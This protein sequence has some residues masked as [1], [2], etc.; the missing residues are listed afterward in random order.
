MRTSAFRGTFQPNARPYLQIASDVFVS[1]Q[2]ETSVISCGECRREVNFNN[3]ITQISTEASVDSPPGSASFTLSIPENDVNDF[4]VDDQLTIIPMM[5]VEIFAKGYFTVG[6]I[7]QYYKIFWGMVSTVTKSWSNG[8]TTIQVSCKDILR[9]WELTNV[10]LN[11][12]YLTSFGS[13]TNNFTMFGNQFASMNPYTVIVQLAKEA[14]GDFS[15]TQGSFTSFTPDSGAESQVIGAYA[16]DIMAYW[17][18][19]FANIWNSLV[20]YGSSGRSYTFSGE[21]GT[22][23]GSQI[24]KTIIEQEETINKMEGDAAG[25]STATS[26]SAFKVH[27]GQLAAFKTELARAADIDFFQT[28]SESKLSVALTARDQAGYEFYCDTTGDIVFKPP[29]YN[30]NV[31]PNKPVS[32][33]QDF[34]IIDDS[35]TDSEAEVYTHITSSGNAFSGGSVDLGLNDDIT[36]PR[37][38]VFD[39]HLLRR[40]GWRR[41]DYQCEWASN[42]RQLFFHLIDHL[43]RVNSKR[44]NGSVTIPMRSELRMGFP[45]WIPKH[46]SFFYINGITHNHS[47]GGQSTSSLTLSAKRSK[48]IAPSNIGK[49]EKVSSPVQTTSKTDPGTG[50]KKQVSG[51]AK[52]PAEQKQQQKPQTTY[53]ITFPQNP[54][55][56]SGI[57]QGAEQGQPQI[58]RDPS[59]GKL[60]GFPNVCMVFQKPFDG[61]ILAKINLDTPGSKKATVE[62]NAAKKQQGSVK[63]AAPKQNQGNNYENVIKSVMKATSGQQ[64]AELIKRL[65]AHRYET[66]MTNAGAYD[67]AYDVGNNFKE[68]TM[69]PVGLVTWGDGSTDPSARAFGSGAE[70]EAEKKKARELEKSQIDGQKIIKNAAFQKYLSAIGTYSAALKNFN[71]AAKKSLGGKKLEA[72]QALPPEVQALKDLS[73]KAKAAEAEANNTYKAEEKRLDELITGSQTKFKTASKLNMMVRPVS[74]EFGFELIG[75]YRYGRGAFIDRGKIQ[76]ADPNNGTIANKLNIQFAATG[77]L[78][79][80]GPNT[81][82]GGPASM[83][84]SQAFEDMRPEDYTTGA[85]FDHGVSG[86]GE[87]QNIST[88][89]QNTYDAAIMASK[90]RTGTIVFADADATRRGVTL[91]ELKPTTTTGLSPGFEKCGCQLGKTDWLSVLPKT[92]LDQILR[93]FSSANNPRIA[94]LSNESGTGNFVSSVST[95]VT[96]VR[97]PSP[98]LVPPTAETQRQLTDAEIDLAIKNKFK[99]TDFQSSA[100]SDPFGFSKKSSVTASDNSPQEI[101][102]RGGEFAPNRIPINTG[103]FFDVLST[104][105][106]ERFTTDYVSNTIREREDV[107]LNFGSVGDDSNGLEQSNYLENPDAALFDRAASGDPAALAALQKDANFNFGRTS[108]AAEDFNQTAEENIDRARS[109]IVNLP[110]QVAFAAENGINVSVTTDSQKGQQIEEARRALEKAEFDLRK[111]EDFLRAN[112]GSTFAQNEVNRCKN[113]YTLASITYSNLTGSSPQSSTPAAAA[114]V[115]GATTAVLD[116]MAKAA[117]NPKD[118]SIQ[119][120][121]EKAKVELSSAQ[122]DLKASKNGKVNVSPVPQNTVPVRPPTQGGILNPSKFGP[123][124]GSFRIGDPFP[125]IPS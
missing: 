78:L 58:I 19:K 8:V 11:P 52:K 94:D 4:Y 5:E 28:D 14:M 25:A 40:Y 24:T 33:I 106:I 67:Y 26:D 75:H 81:D 51:K 74:D 60:L 49:I 80:D 9:W 15:L 45:V 101:D 107:G 79:T 21:G 47:V 55:D 34:E 96:P 64:Q 35:I 43:D 71:D 68:I 73:D 109:A 115:E 54:G 99:D 59:T 61:D 44:Q 92:A 42:P 2:G 120:A 32:W 86:K 23:S 88:T 18:L 104:Y 93:P 38:G 62:K 98:S 22:V 48:F 125:K 97:S 116:L 69:V 46:D 6:G 65:R 37:T 13:S 53:K 36:T 87:V 66:G 70:F 83:S 12:A 82:T 124:F 56:T 90:K 41:L 84:F 118:G 113:I 117:A 77:G 95:T 20:L 31:L 103:S 72:N 3:Y 119:I 39:Y 1:L 63:G 102:S 17:Q 50:T 105:L 27:I 85:S 111:A 76:I 122:T 123:D 29:F 110:D 57:S 7:P 112:P 114:R 91:A 89:G 108:E 100:F 121:L 10:T 30:L 16:K